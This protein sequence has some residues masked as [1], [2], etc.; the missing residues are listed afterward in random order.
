M[1]DRLDLAALLADPARVADVPPDSALDGTNA[2][3]LRDVAEHDGR[4]AQGLPHTTRPHPGRTRRTTRRRA[5]LGRAL[6][7][8][9]DGDA[10]TSRSA[11]ADAHAEVCEGKA[12][13]PL[14]VQLIEEPLGD[15]NE[16]WREV[17]TLLH[18]AGQA[19]S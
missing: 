6:G 15:A 12:P 4:Q 5:Q 1:T 8:G 14:R 2:I 18:R 16:R 7:D 3:V 19:A 13:W 11:T 17:L 10:R 9:R